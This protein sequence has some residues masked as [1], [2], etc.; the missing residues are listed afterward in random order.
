MIEG[1]ANSSLFEDNRMLNLVLSL[2]EE[3]QIKLD[4]NKWIN[5]KKKTQK[6]QY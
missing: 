3:K 1:L 5:M 6:K 2:S 4:K